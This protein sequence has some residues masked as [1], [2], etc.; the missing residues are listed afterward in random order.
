MSAPQA[1]ARAGNARLPGEHAEV[2]EAVVAEALTVPPF[3]QRAAGKGKITITPDGLSLI[4]SLAALGGGQALIASHL[5]IHQ[6]TFQRLLGGVDPCEPRLAFEKGRA[7]FEIELAT[8]LLAQPHGGPEEGAAGR[9]GRL[10]RAGGRA[11][12]PDD[13]LTPQQAR[14]IR[15][16][17]GLSQKEMALALGLGTEIGVS[18]YERGLTQMKGPI[19][20]IYRLLAA[21]IVTTEQIYRALGLENDGRY[22]ANKRRLGQAARQRRAALP[23]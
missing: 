9:K 22:R 5:G 3:I 8:V 10:S 15:L 14:E 21:R 17:L 1:A 18:R 7:H 11:A 4:T 20:V 2:H 16:Q 19:L 6:R 23:S 12:R 13:T